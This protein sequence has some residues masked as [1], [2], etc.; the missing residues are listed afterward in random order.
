M[1]VQARMEISMHR[2][3]LGAAIAAACGLIQSVKAEAGE[4]ATVELKVGATAVK[5]AP[6]AGANL[7]SIQIHG[8]ELLRQPDKPGDFTGFRYGTPVLYPT[9]NRVRD[10]SFTWEGKTYKFDA[11]ER[12]NFLH[13]LVHS[14]A[15]TVVSQNVENDKATVVC[16]LPFEPGKPWF[17]KFPFP[18]TLRLTIEVRDGAV[19]WTYAVDNS[20]GT[21][22][23]P[24]GFALHPWFLY[25]GARK[26]THLTVPAKHFMEAEGMLPTGKLVPLEGTKFDARRGLSLEGFVIDDVYH[27]MTS[28]EPVKIQ[29]ADKS[30]AV[31]LRASDD[32]THLVVYTPAKEP[33]FCVENQTCSTDAHNLFNKGLKDESHLIVV[34]PGKIHTGWVEFSFE[35][36]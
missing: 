5:F 24:M 34:P 16:E 4:T 31:A 25:Q 9:P 7:Y 35:K 10:A 6:Q 3:W 23:I 1:F 32:F 36:K 13:G 21:A 30:V 2:I 19:K 29:F 18:H 14:A 33:W 8:T 22:A 15:W 20:K 28:A 11:N 12:T 17:E 27:G 26:D